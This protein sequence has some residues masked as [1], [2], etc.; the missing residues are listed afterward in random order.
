MRSLT[1]LRDWVRDEQDLDDR[2]DKRYFLLAATAMGQTSNIEEKL[3]RLMVFVGQYLLF[4]DKHSGLE[5]PAKILK[6]KTGWCDQQCKVFR[7]FAWN[8][9]GVD[10]HDLAIFH[11]DGSNGHTVTEVR[12]DGIWHLFDVH[13]DHQAVYR[14]PSSGNILSYDEIVKDPRPVLAERHWWK[15]NNGVG[16]VG[17]YQPDKG[18]TVKR[19]H[20]SA[21]T[22][23]SDTSAAYIM[24]SKWF[25]WLR[26]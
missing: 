22:W 19:G 7:Y 20:V 4:A 16:K 21:Q 3:I 24:I 8:L 5:D 25:D 26:E 17:F 6:D 13:G 1:E 12:Y 23:Y 2:R 15:G 18:S 9:L 11:T 10:G 14:S